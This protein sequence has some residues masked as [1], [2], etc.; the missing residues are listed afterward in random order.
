MVLAVFHSILPGNLYSSLRWQLSLFSGNIFRQFYPSVTQ[1]FKQKSIFVSLIDTIYLATS[2]IIRYQFESTQLNVLLNMVIEGVGLLGFRLCNKIKDA[3]MQSGQRIWSSC[4]ITP[5]KWIAFSAG[6]KVSVSKLLLFCTRYL[7]VMPRTKVFLTP[8][9]MCTPPVSLRYNAPPAVLLCLPALLAQPLR[10]AAAIRWQDVL[11]G[12]CCG[13]R[14]LISTT[15]GF[16]E[17]KHLI[18][19]MMDFCKTLRW[20]ERLAKF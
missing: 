1:I 15:C 12:V 11:Q 16:P 10:G 14:T 6:I 17:K 18:C 7:G 9:P 8:L 19:H 3:I 13:I 4:F 2:C 20:T 5:F